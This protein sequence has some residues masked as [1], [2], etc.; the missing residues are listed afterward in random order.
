MA[1][2]ELPELFSNTSMGLDAAIDSPDV[3]S[4]M[5]TPRNI[6]RA[7][8]HCFSP[9]I[10][11]TP[12]TLPSPLIEEE[13]DEEAIDDE[14]Q[15]NHQKISSKLRRELPSPLSAARLLLHL[16]PRR[17][18]SNSKKHLRPI[19]EPCNDAVAEPSPNDS[20][21]VEHFTSEDSTCLTTTPR[22][23]ILFVLLFVLLFPSFLAYVLQKWFGLSPRPIAPPSPFEISSI[24]SLHT[25]RPRLVDAFILPT[26]VG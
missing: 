4:K 7:F 2:I 15:V 22:N 1:P 10:S 3:P 5:I 16:S 8:I 12:N 18:S 11:T 14:N 26:P 6:G 13:E 19:L 25:E 17:P 9:R 20:T 23:N 24:I 21:V